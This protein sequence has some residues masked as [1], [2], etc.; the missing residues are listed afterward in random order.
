VQQHLVALAVNLQLAESL[1]ESDSFA[2]TKLLKEIGRDVQRALDETAQLAQRI[3][4]PL[5]ELG[6]FAASLRS[7]VVSAGI[8][9]SVEVSAGSNYPP[10]IAN[11]VYSFWLE[12]LEHGSTDTPA[13]IT[14]REE[15]GALTFEIV[16]DSDQPDGWLDRLRDRVEA[17]GGRV[18]I[19]SQPGHG[20]RLC[21]SLPLSR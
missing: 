14:V 21:G 11:T 9:A 20:V 10:E 19:E 7:A 3:Y 5:L 6:G 16:R 2:A 4:P 18:R 1:L 12:A 17:L 15:I 8:P 13:A